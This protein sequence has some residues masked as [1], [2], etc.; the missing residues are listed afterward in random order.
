MNSIFLTGTA[1]SGKSQLT[2]RLTDSFIQNDKEVIAV[3]LDPGVNNL[4]YSA[5]IDIRD[6]IN[7]NEIMEKYNLGPNGAVI[8][9][10]DLIA[11]KIDEINDTI[12]TYNPDYVFFDT[13]G[14]IELF[15]FRTSGPFFV[16]NIYGE[17]R[18]NI[19]LCDSTLISKPEN[20]VSIALLASSIKL[21]LKIPQICVLS[22]QDLINNENL[23]KWAEDPTEIFNNL[24]KNGEMYDLTSR[25]AS[26]LLESDLFDELI[27]VSS[28][29]NQGI[30]EIT[31]LLSRIL[32]RG[33]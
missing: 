2:S 7:I 1:G 18:A 24:P 17:G 19:F 27:P 4:P 22:K 32:T 10:A 23:L 29:N 33:D 6:F 12:Q 9:A 30:V 21:Q 28:M 16:Q 11:S 20:F 5:D 14:Q 13:P 25:I 3:N 8:L 26:N 15:A 31:A